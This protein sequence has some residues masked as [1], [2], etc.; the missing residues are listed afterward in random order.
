M[1]GTRK[2]GGA[3]AVV[4]IGPYCVTSTKSFRHF[5]ECPRE[6]LFFC[7]VFFLAFSL[8]NRR[9]ARVKCFFFPVAVDEMLFGRFVLFAA[10]DD[11]SI[12]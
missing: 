7:S 6:F 2:D 4:D 11:T 12:G 10:V 3:V 5:C 9:A 1:S 8:G